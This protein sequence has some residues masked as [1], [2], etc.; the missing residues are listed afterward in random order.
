MTDDRNKYME[1]TREN[2]DVMN[3][4]IA[5]LEAI[6]KK[7]TGEARRDL[8]ERLDSI[9]ESRKKAE[10][11]LEELRRASKPAWDDVKHGFEDAWKS[12]ST[13]VDRATDRFQ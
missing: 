4:K 7:K 5:E 10:G 9:R 1:M 12:L 2:L 11:R 3:A 8:G 6:A 13:A